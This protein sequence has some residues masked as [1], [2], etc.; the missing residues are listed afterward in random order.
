MLT[1]FCDSYGTHDIYIGAKSIQ[2]FVDF[3]KDL[4][5]QKYIENMINM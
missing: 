2:D 4:A 1:F 3:F 5:S